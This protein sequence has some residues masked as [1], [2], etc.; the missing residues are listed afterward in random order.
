VTTPYPLI[1]K[2]KRKGK[3]KDKEKE[4]DKDKVKKEK[5]KVPIPHTNVY[6]CRESVIIKKKQHKKIDAER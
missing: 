3:A 5:R 6:R 4:K 2:R 1:K